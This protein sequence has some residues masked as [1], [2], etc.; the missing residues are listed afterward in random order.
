[1]AVIRRNH[2]LQVKRIRR[3]V[4]P[5]TRRSPLPDMFIRTMHLPLPQFCIRL[6]PRSGRLRPAPRPKSDQSALKTLKSLHLTLSFTYIWV[7]QNL[8][9]Q[10]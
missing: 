6:R 10:P 7:N 9:Q 2:Q 5:L 8:T 1:M 3:W 4:E